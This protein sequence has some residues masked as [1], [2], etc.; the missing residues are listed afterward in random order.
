[1]KDN[2]NIDPRCYALAEIV[3]VEKDLPKA[4]GEFFNTIP[5]QDRRH[6]YHGLLLLLA[7]NELDLQ[8]ISD[9]MLLTQSA[10]YECQ[11]KMFHIQSQWVVQH[12]LMPKGVRHVP[13]V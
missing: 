9:F 8:T 2:A 6:V 4:V 13:V 10:A 11:I 5:D 1:M 12:L 3:V 7:S